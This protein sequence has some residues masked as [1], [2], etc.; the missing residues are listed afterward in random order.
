MKSRLTRPRLAIIFIVIAGFTILFTFALRSQTGGDIHV[1]YSSFSPWPDGTKAVYLTLSKLGYPVERLRRTVDEVPEESTLLLIKPLFPVSNATW[2]KL[3]KFM[4]SGGRVILVG[5]STVDIDNS[6]LVQPRRLERPGIVRAAAPT[7][8]VRALPGA[9]FESDRRLQSGS[10]AAVTH[11]GDND[12]ALLISI[13]RGRGELIVLADA[14]LLAN[15]RLKT[16]PGNIKL[17]LAALGPPEPG[18]PIVFDEWHHG[19]IAPEMP[20][21]GL[22]DLPV[23]VWGA[24]PL[25][26]RLILLQALLLTALWFY[27]DGKRVGPPVPLEDDSQPAANYIAAMADLYRRAGARRF[28]FSMIYRRFIRDLTGEPGNGDAGDERAVMRVVRH[29]PVDADAVGAVVRASRTMLAP[30]A[31]ISERELVEAVDR[32]DRIREGLRKDA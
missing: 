14:S 17:I 24:L 19:L 7:A 2:K 23:R 1:P 20:Q 22:A 26:A 13:R 5:G 15:S 10:A 31:D 11:F 12:G 18:R 21:G 30:G 29:R 4:K 28:A 32:L 16:D 3:D 27:S 9:T 25:W 6:K 8:L